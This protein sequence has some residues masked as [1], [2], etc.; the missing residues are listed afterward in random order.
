MVST[1]YASLAV[2]LASPVLYVIS[3][4]LAR[5]TDLSPVVTNDNDADGFVMEYK[6]SR[7]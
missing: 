3:P 2:S 6:G 1:L 7:L 4:S 5:F